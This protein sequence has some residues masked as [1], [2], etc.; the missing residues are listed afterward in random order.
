MAYGIKQDTDRNG[1]LWYY[2]TTKTSVLPSKRLKDKQGRFIKFPE[3]HLAENYVGMLKDKEL[4]GGN[5]SASIKKKDK[6]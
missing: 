2:I 5:P 1:R 4:R 6:K 3:L